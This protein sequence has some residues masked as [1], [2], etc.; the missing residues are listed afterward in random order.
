MTTPYTLGVVVNSFNRL[1]LLKTSLLALADW[2]PV[3]VFR[4]HHMVVIFDAGSTDGSLEWLASPDSLP[5]LKY[6]VIVPSG[7]EESSFS[8]G[9]NRAVN[10]LKEEYPWIQFLLLYETDNLINEQAPVLQAIHLLQTQADL[11]A[12]GFTV[13]KY[14]GT[15]AGVGQPFPTLLNFALGKRLVYWLQLEAITYRWKQI[16]PNLEFSHVDVV[17]TSPLVVSMQSWQASGGFNAALFPFSDCDVDWAR[18]LRSLGWKMG[19][20]KTDGVIHDN[21]QQLSE[22]SSMRALNSHCARLQY[23][24]LRNPFSIYL[25]WPFP[26]LLRHSLE[27]ITATLIIRDPVRSKQLRTQYSRLMASCFARYSGAGKSVAAKV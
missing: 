23:F 17:Y 13:Q 12:C 25:V 16:S 21:R 3:S 10:Y 14:D 9:V 2:L 4:N 24:R 26:L 19:V 8:A 27:W 6:K 5:D 7:S 1:T 22:W 18:R 15:A 11:A 20:I